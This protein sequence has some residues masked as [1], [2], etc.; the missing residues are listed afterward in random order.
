MRQCHAGVLTSFFEGNALLSAPRSLSTGRPVGAIRLQQ[1]DPL[2]VDGGSFLVE[3]PTDPVASAEAMTAGFLKLWDEI[4]SGRLD[5][6]AIRAKANS[7]STR[8]QMPKL[9]E[10][11]RQLAATRT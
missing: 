8:V 5:P 11:H 1:F 3:R 2:I 10:R 4:Q 9:F 7:Y 6:A